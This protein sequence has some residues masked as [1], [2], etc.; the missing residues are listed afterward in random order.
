V[1]IAELIRAQSTS[2]TA[3]E[4]RVAEAIL[5]SPQAVG[6][7]TVADL[8][9]AAG[10]GAA[11]VVRLAAKLG[12]DGFSALQAC[13]QRDLLSQLRPAAERI[14]ESTAGGR[15][16]HAAVELANVQAT[17]DGV[18][19]SALRQ[20]TL[21]L[22]DLERPVRVVSGEATAGV[23]AQFV[24]QLEQ[25]RPEVGMLIGSDVAVRREL[26]LLSPRSTVLVIDLRRYEQWVL[27]THDM[28]SERG[29]WSAGFTDSV[30]S[31][32]AAKADVTFVLSAGSTGP[33]DSH[34]GTLALLNLIAVRVADELRAFATDR[35]TA[36]ESAWRA[37]GALVDGG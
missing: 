20:L 29:I 2:L 19:E 25:L 37:S 1:E 16:S 30:L 35:L 9:S 11:S 33:F 13:I 36:I 24:A 18:E 7:G 6:F 10:V 32:V 26:A 5:A 12:F 21:R 22:S 17:L 14:R 15:D 27:D 34:V 3:A 23:A 8:A 4:R 28:A 31:P